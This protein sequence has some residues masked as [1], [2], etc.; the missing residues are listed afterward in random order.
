M[1]P[2]GAHGAG[3]AGGRP[4]RAPRGHHQHRGRRPPSARAP[5]S[6]ARQ[7]SPHRAG[8]GVEHGRARHRTRSATERPPSA[9]PATSAQWRP[10]PTASA[11][12]DAERGDWRK[13]PTLLLL[14]NS[15]LGGT[16][17]LP[18]PCQKRLLVAAAR[19]RRARLRARTVQAMAGRVVVG[20]SSW[21][22]PGLRRGLV[23][24]G[25]PARDRLPWYAERFQAVELN[26]SFYGVPA[27]STVQR[28]DEVTPPGS[29]STSSSIACSHA[30]P[31]ASTR[32]RPTSATASRPVPAAASG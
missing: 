29:P 1:P 17:C 14:C 27:E 20:T 13:H 23:P 8:T 31:P 28:W 11:G 7:G 30:T 4:A 18:T 25:M 10:P 32:C 24:E 19:R 9:T 6:A 26:A 22:D 12:G 3:G 21:A 5:R 15:Q 16:W 2:G